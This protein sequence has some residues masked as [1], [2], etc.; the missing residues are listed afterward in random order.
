MSNNTPQDFSA[1]PM[2]IGNSL[3]RTALTPILSRMDQSQQSSAQAPTATVA[4]STSLTAKTGIRNSTS[5]PSQTHPPHS[6]G[7]AHHSSSPPTTA[8]PL[9]QLVNFPSRLVL[10]NVY[11]NG[12]HSLRRFG[13]KNTSATD[14]I[15]KMRS[16]LGA[17]ISFQLTNE[18]LPFDAGKF[19]YLLYALL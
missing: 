3:L 15:V 6:Q 13:I 12:L 1:R 10:E 9:F 5:L 2:D 7:S 4:T 16:S 14:I 18:N 11:L 17:Q 8:T 19:L